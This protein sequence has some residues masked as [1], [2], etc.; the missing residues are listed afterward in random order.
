MDKI[1]LR[2]LIGSIPAIA[3]QPGV[4]DCAG[5]D[6]VAIA[7]ATYFEDRDDRPKDDPPSPESES[8]GAWTIEKTDAALDRIVDVILA[9]IQSN[10]AI[11]HPASHE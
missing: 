3:Y 5:E 8:W 9:E 6:N 11:S 2:N 4:L 10:K 7:L 1:K